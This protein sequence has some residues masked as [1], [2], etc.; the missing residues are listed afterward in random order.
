LE[1]GKE[2]FKPAAVHPLRLRLF[3]IC[4]CLVRPEMMSWIMF[5][6][7]IPVDRGCCGNVFYFVVYNMWF[8]DG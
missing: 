6:V 2:A 5:I 1:A 3:R 4:R 7:Y 8:M